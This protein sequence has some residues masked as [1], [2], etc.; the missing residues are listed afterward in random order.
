MRVVQPIQT[1]EERSIS[2]SGRRGEQEAIE[3]IYSLTASTV[4]SV[5]SRVGIG[6]GK[7][8]RFRVITGAKAR[9]DSARQVRLQ[10]GVV[11]LEKLR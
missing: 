5:N 11:A 2:W 1:V 4:L 9:A 10:I 3:A 8:S 7:A 6:K